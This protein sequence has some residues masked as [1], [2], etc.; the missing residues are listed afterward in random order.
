M[1]PVAV[2]TLEDRLAESERRRV[3]AEQVAA[4]A[5]LLLTDEQRW[6]VRRRL[7]GAVPPEPALA[8]TG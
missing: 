2:K 7:A 3:L 1:S 5:C 8:A 4:E 6:E